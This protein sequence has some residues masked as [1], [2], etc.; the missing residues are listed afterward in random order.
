MILIKHK[1]SYTVENIR[2]ENK[3]SYFST[4]NLTSTFICFKNSRKQ[5]EAQD[6]WLLYFL[7]RKP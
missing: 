7:K 5:K 1:C 2:L 4:S 6:K 3:Q